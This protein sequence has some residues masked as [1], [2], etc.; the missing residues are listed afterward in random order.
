MTPTN[1]MNPGES[2][3]SDGLNRIVRNNRLTLEFLERLP[4]LISMA[5][6]IEIT[7]LTKHGVRSAVAAGSLRVFRQTGSRKGKYYR[8]EI[9]ALIGMARNGK[10][11]T[12]SPGSAARALPVS[13][14]TVHG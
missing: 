10:I 13:T 1:C 5:T 12:D 3:R 14:M 2:I 6:V 8:D 11:G 9:I 4:F 7:G